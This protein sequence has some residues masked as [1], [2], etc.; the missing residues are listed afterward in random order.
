[1]D[2][3]RKK[4]PAT[5]IK[6]DAYHIAYDPATTTVAFRGTLRL[7]GMAEYSPIKQLLDEVA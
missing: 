7:R 4:V 3:T 1:V 5:E 6:E 2:L